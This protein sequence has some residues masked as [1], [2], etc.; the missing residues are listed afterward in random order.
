LLA[1]DFNSNSISPSKWSTGNLFSGTTDTTIGNGATNQQL[2]IGPLKVNAAG[3]HYNRLR[4]ASTYNFTCAYCYVGLM[5]TPANNTLAD[6]MF[7]IGTDINNYYRIYVEGGSLIGQ[8]KAAGTK[9]TLFTQAYNAVT[10]KYVR[11]RHDSA[12]GNAVLEVAPDNS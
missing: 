9:A 3:S 7:T 1:D 4:S 10:N 5:T 11:I 6:A 12:S 2:Q 8:R